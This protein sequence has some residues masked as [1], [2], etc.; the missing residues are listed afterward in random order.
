[1]SH[2]VVVTVTETPDEVEKVL[3]PFD[4]ELEVE[5]Y[6]EYIEKPNDEWERHLKLLEEHPEDRDEHDSDIVSFLSSWYESP[7]T[8]ED[9]PD[10]TKLY[11]YLSTSNPN[12]KWDWWVIGGRWS[13]FFKVKPGENGIQGNRTSFSFD[14]P[15]AAAD[16]SW[17]DQVRKEQVDFNTMRAHAV[18]EANEEF[19]KYEETIEGLPLPQRWEEIRI[20]SP[21][22]EVAREVYNEQPYIKALRNSKEF[23]DVFTDPIDT[24]GVGR[25]KFVERAKNRAGIPYAIVSEGVWRQK[26][27]MGWWGMSTDEMGQDEWNELIQKFYDQ[28]PAKALLT[29]VD[30]HI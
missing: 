22:I 12:S 5:P 4:E 1:L 3:A 27:Q 15:L 6:K 18:Q 14:E 8:M 25:E 29:A 11:S 19:T 24:Y 16:P 13:G 17:A 10:G 20:A 21:T 28:L 23:W 9:S 30:C 2:F 7:V 26:G